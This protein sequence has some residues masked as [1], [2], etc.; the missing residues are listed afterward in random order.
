VSARSAPGVFVTIIVDDWKPNRLAIFDSSK[1]CLLIIYKKNRNGKILNEGDDDG[2]YIQVRKG[3]R[4][5][6]KWNR[7]VC[8]CRFTC[9]KTFKCIEVFLFF[10]FIFVKISNK[11]PKLKPKH[12]LSPLK[13]FC[14]NWVFKG[15]KNS[16][17]SFM[18]ELLGS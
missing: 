9:L 15:F 17:L 5:R 16:P 1:I 10:F 12:Q 11:P 7:R 18:F 4:D 14:S 3:G 6:R 13:F 8:N 2:V